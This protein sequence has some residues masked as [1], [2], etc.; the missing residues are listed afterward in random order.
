MPTFSAVAGIQVLL[1]SNEFFYYFNFMDHLL[2]NKP[3]PENDS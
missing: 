2:P 3:H 1:L